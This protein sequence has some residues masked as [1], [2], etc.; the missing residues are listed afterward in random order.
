MN[1]EQSKNNKLGNLEKA[2]TQFHTQ[3]EQRNGK[4]EHIRN[5]FDR[6][7][8]LAKNLQYQLQQELNARGYERSLQV[9]VKEVNAEDIK[10]EPE[11]ARLPFQKEQPYF[12]QFWAL[13]VTHTKIQLVKPKQAVIYTEYF[14][15]IGIGGNKVPEFL[16]DIKKVDGVIPYLDGILETELEDILESMNTHATKVVEANLE[17]LEKNS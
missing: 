12:T 5:N 2:L 3:L 16:N 10:D 4:I 7:R 14:P 8:N 6:L 1:D 15:V 13:E 9:T 17:E 11:I